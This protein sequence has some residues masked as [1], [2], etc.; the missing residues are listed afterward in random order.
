MAHLVLAP[1]LPLS[2]RATVGSWTLI[3]FAEARASDVVPDD[4]R[5]TTCRLIDAYEVDDGLG[6][7]GAIVEPS[8]GV[9]TE[10]DRAAMGPPG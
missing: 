9:G 7:P 3:P 2:E 1:Y 8:T 5:R 6:V 10:V 4:L